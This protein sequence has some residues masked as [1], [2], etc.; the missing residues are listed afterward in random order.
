MAGFF[1]H[2]IYNSV[3]GWGTNDSHLIRIIVTRSEI[4]M[5]EI[6]AIYREQHEQSLEEVIESECSGDYKK[7]LI[8]IVRMQE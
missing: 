2:R 4:D 1:A 3:R 7:I 8:A 6:D 5:E